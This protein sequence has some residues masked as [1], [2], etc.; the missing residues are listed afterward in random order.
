[1]AGFDNRSGFA[2]GDV[3]LAPYMTPSQD[4][5]EHQ[6]CV[7][8]SSSTYNQQRSDVLVMAVVIQNRPDSSTGEMAVQYA[9]AAGL[10]KG[11]ALKPVLATIDQRH[12]RLIVGHLKGTDRER[13]R[14]LLQLIVGG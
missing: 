9:E 7:V 1:M 8:I 4:K 12:V 10:D 2:F 6:P 13:L 14:H 5:A 11:A 3:L